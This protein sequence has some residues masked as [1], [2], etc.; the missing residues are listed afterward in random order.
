M[1]KQGETGQT[2]VRMVEIG[3]KLVEIDENWSKIGRNWSKICW[4]LFRD[5]R[6]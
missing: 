4:Y 6:M 3:R 5:I 1:A 2:D